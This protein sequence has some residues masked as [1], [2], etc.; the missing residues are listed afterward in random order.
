MN[1][2]GGTLLLFQALLIQ[3]IGAAR[4]A[5]LFVE[6]LITDDNPSFDASGKYVPP[7]LGEGGSPK[8]RGWIRLKEAG[9]AKRIKSPF[10]AVRLTCPR[11]KAQSPTPSHVRRAAYMQQLLQSEN[12]VPRCFF[13][14]EWYNGSKIQ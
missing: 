12:F 9:S 14:V 5:C 4:L 13:W 3:V 10:A 2:A 11:R 1:K 8:G 6:C 7:W